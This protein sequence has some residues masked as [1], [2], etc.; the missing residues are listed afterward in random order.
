MAEP[1]I[2]DQYALE[3]V[4]RARQDPKAEADR[5]N[6]NLNEGLPNGT[7]TSTPKQ[8]L[9]FNP[10]LF[11]AAQSHTQWMLDNQLFG[12]A[13]VN[14]SA[15]FDRIADAGYTGSTTRENL[16]ATFTNDTNPDLVFMA[17]ANY[18]DLFVDKSNAERAHRITI[19]E[20]K[21]REVGISNIL[22]E[23]SGLNA[24]FVTLDYGTRSDVNPFLTGVV[25]N[26]E[27]KDSFYTPGEG[28]GGIQVEI[29]GSNGNFSTETMNTGG[30]QID[31]PKGNY[32]ITFSG[33]GLNSSI[34][35]SA[36]IDSENVKLDAVVTAVETNSNS[37]TSNNSLVGNSKNNKL[38]GTQKNETLEGQGG[39]DTLNGAG[40]NDILLG[41]AGNDRLNGGAGKDEMTGGN[42]NDVYVVNST[43]DRVTEKGNRGQ[44][45]VQAS[46][47]YSLGKNLENLTLTGKKSLN[48]TGNN[49]DNNIAG[50]KAKNRLKGNAG[51]DTLSGGGG[52]DI[53]IGNA[54]KD[55]LNGDAGND[56]LTGGGGSDRLLGNAG[57][58]DL[59]GDA[60]NDTLTGGS[61]SDRFIYSTNRRFRN[62]D[63]GEDVITDFLVGT[64]I[65]VLDKT[66][67]TK[68][69]STSNDNFLEVVNRDGKVTSS[70]A[71]IVYNSSSGELFYNA[72]G[73]NNG[74]GK[75]GLFAT[76]QD[77][78][79][80]EATDFRVQN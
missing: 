43:G 51:N 27:D 64:D 20:D 50:N 3:L 78:P 38:Q 6:I 25:Y 29:R 48:G 31:L 8:P 60:G 21:L 47:N 59:N 32:T 44:D 19:M 55:R 12:H 46:V 16:G 63:L 37:T 26:D 33:E 62:S 2:Y 70:S 53:L 77:K 22:G 14:G 9:A 1:T 39:N 52:N 68:V 13:G 75:G 5:Y 30:Y 61:G 58:D 4:N 24:L 66:T 28:L 35:K 49:L 74:F 10:N 65:I 73:S 80:L 7:I 23:F 57:K 79:A 45:R 42:G 18:E 76:L 15:S 67:F 36:S 69:K 17:D 11:N 40:G 56:T 34:T 41:G 71:F 54:G 72:N